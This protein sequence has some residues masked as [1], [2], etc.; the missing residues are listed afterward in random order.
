M[1]DMVI[2]RD[3]EEADS[4]IS[5]WEYDEGLDGEAQ[6]IVDSDEVA[7][8][9]D[10]K[11]L[12]Q[13]GPGRHLINGDNQPALA[14][15]MDDDDAQAIDV[16][17][18]RTSNFELFFDQRAGDV[19]DA[20]T[21]TVF[22]AWLACDTLEL[23]VL[24]VNKVID[25][26]AQLDGE[27]SFE[28]FVAGIAHKRAMLAL[29]SRVQPLRNLLEGPVELDARGLEAAINGDLKAVD[30]GVTIALKAPVVCYVADE[31]VEELRSRLG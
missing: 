13:L 21:S 25:R 11:P 15:Y 26:V 4:L 8:F 30:V 1:S 23:K 28:E 19:N 22:G 20:A 24:D 2:E 31:D 10:E 9:F 29:A 5:W 7:V 12:L 27:D 17:F 18:V 3:E 16:A 6:V 14:D